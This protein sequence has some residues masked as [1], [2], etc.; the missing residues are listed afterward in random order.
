MDS[1]YIPFIAIPSVTAAIIATVIIIMKCGRVCYRPDNTAMVA[2]VDE[3]NT[4]GN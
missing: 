3:K 2:P 1:A 4:S